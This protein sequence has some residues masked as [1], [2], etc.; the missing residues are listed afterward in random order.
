MC[1]VII[2]TKEHFLH[3]FCLWKSTCILS[4]AHFPSSGGAPPLMVSFLNPPPHLTAPRVL[5]E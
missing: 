3:F 5:S 4:P 2:R 1:T